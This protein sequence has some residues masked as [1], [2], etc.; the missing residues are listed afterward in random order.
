MHYFVDKFLVSGIENSLEAR[1]NIFETHYSFW[2]QLY[3][4][5]ELLFESV[6]L[7]LCNDW[8]SLRKTE[9]EQQWQE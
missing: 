2:S 9:Q 4:E 1:K 5:K 7:N 6:D 8:P 3:T